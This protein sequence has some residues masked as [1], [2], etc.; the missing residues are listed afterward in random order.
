MTKKVSTMTKDE[1]L[2]KHIPHRINLLITYRERYLG[3]SE[4]DRKK[5]GELFRDFHRCSKDIS[6]L[7]VR[8]LLGE[9]GVNLRKGD[10]DISEKNNSSY[11]DKLRIKDVICNHNYISILEVLNVANRAVAHMEASDVNHAIELDVDDDILFK[12][13]DFTE[14]MCIKNMYEYNSFDYDKIMSYVDNNMHRESLK[15]TDL[16]QC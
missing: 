12:T 9:L 10:K 8:F 5:I 4:D 16:I 6:M 11:T 7:M 15:L 2:K 1:Y 13:I 3:Y 14:Q